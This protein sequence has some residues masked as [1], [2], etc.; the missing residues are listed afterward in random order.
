MVAASRITV[1]VVWLHEPH[2]SGPSSHRRQHG[3]QIVHSLRCASSRA[4][5]STAACAA[6][7]P[8]MAVDAPGSIASAREPGWMSSSRLR[9][10]PSSTRRTITNS[11]VVLPFSN[12]DTHLREM[13]VRSARA[14]WLSLRSILRPRTAAATSATER[15]RTGTPDQ[16]ERQALACNCTVS[17]SWRV[18]VRCQPR[19]CSRL[20][21]PRSWRCSDAKCWRDIDAPCPIRNLSRAQWARRAPVAQPDRAA[22]F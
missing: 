21:D 4:S 5:R 9:L 12:S 11:A 18:T 22:A 19:H 13:P 6:R 14:A 10:S 17:P 1:R 16:Q 3:Q 20:A 7:G 2:C 15:T 8:A